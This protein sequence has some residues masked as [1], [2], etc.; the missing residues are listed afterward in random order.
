MRPTKKLVVAAAIAACA[1]AHAEDAHAW[2]FPEHVVLTHD[3]IVQLP[4]EIRAVIRDAVA[5]SKRDGLDLCAA[6]DVRLSDLAQRRLLRT[7]MLRSELS[8]DCVPYTALS[9]FAGD[10]ASSAGELR[11]VLAS[12]KGLEITSA[13]AYEWHRFEEAMGR[14][15]NQSVERMSFVHD[16]DV[17][18]YFIDPGYEVRAG[19][20]RSHFVDAGRPLSDV[21]RDA[22]VAGAL[23]N[24]VG[25]F[26]AH[27]LRSL[28]L[29]ARGDASNAVLEHGFALH[30]LQDAFS[31]GHLVMTSSTWA[32]KGNNGTRRRHD[33]FDAK[34]LRVGRATNVESCPSH[35][36]PLDACWTTMGDGYLGVAPDSSDRTHV[37]R[38]VAKAELEL[39]IAFD[40]ASVVEV[41]EKMSDR[42]KVAIGELLDPQPWWTLTRDERD[43]RVPS[44]ARAVRYMRGTVDAMARLKAVT[45]PPEVTVGTQPPAPL[46]EASWVADA[47]EPCVARDVDDVDGQGAPPPDTPETRLRT[48]RASR[49]AS[50]EDDGACGAGRTLAV[51]TV[52]ASLLRPML[53]DLPSSQADADTLDGEA[54]IDHGWA[55]QLLAA[56]N[57]GT[58]FPP[59]QPVEFFAPAVSVSAGFSY[60]WG[61]YLPGRR[62][63]ALAELNVGITESLHYD[64]NARA[65]GYP[66][67]TM[68]DQELRWPIAFEILTAYPLPLDLRRNQTEGA[69]V[70]LSGIRVHELLGNSSIVFWGIEHEIVAVALSRGIGSYPLYASSPELRFH[71]GF[72]DPN[73]AHPSLPHKWGPTLSITFTGGY[74]TFL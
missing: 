31:A 15:P 30:F 24:S 50:V 10:H 3:G 9:A 38:A 68:L 39:A 21:A 58:L 14:L 62:N 4:P 35:G 22:A 49:S 54:H 26:L 46:F 36:G 41:V 52:G 48:L 28:A 2:W 23:D 5:R 66:H 17:D 37:A 29:A 7:K 45:P 63:R 43:R 19:L 6:I 12:K 71:I 25:Q 8:V 16:L 47:F 13:A 11:S 60:R 34:G 27:H 33:Y 18:F 53:V 69:F 20:T 59:H 72:A 64:S 42:E 56:G 70:F 44:A 65:G 57:A 32:A 61:T 55:L 40:G 1:L 51:G 74:A 73:A 67:V